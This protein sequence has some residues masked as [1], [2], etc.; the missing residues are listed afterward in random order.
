MTLG[1]RVDSAPDQASEAA[2][3]TV[4]ALLFT[5]TCKA[6]ALVAI[7]LPISVVSCALATSCPGRGTRFW[8]EVR[9]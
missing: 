2:A 7:C 1:A 5:A 3:S 8:C 4:S 6:L 9:T